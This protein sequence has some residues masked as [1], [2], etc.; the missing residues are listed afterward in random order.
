[1]AGRGGGLGMQIGF[2]LGLINQ[3]GQA[4]AEARYVLRV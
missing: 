1:M 2:Y 3:E 4:S